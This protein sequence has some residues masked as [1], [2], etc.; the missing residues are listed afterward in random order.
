MVESLRLYSKLCK[1][2]GPTG[3]HCMY[4]TKFKYYSSGLCHGI[5]LSV[6]PFQRPYSGLPGL[7]LHC[8]LPPVS[9]VPLQRTLTQLIS[10][11][12]HNT[13]TSS[14]STNTSELEVMLI[15]HPTLWNACVSWVLQVFGI[16]LYQQNLL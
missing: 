3:I 6:F 2:F 4:L 9:S 8:V 14:Y 1:I 7:S 15:G 10:T 12:Q 13:C 11:V 5:T 16:R